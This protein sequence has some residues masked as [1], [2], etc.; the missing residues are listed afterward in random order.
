MKISPIHEAVT[1]SIHLGTAY[2]VRTKC[3]AAYQTTPNDP[4]PIGL[5]GSISKAGLL[6]AEAAR[7]EQEG[8]MA[9]V[10]CNRC[11]KLPLYGSAGGGGGCGGSSPQRKKGVEGKMRW[12]GGGWKAASGTI[13]P[14]G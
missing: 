4:C 14:V 3:A 11:S 6:S 5:S 1:A 9:C 10:E 2:I 12:A 8:W 13:L 7:G